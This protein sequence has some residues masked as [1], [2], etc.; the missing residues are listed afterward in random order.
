[1]IKNIIAVLL[2][3]PFLVFGQSTIFP[4]DYDL[5]IFSVPGT[6]KRVM[7]CLHGYGDN[8]EIVSLLK[9][10]KCMDATL[11]GFN[12]PEYDIKRG[13]KYDYRKAT[14]GTID[15]LLPALYVMK[16]IVLDLGLNSIDLYDS[17][18]EEEL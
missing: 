18:L 8:Y 1:M 7:I 6:S 17:L 11:I 5:H 4:F 2:L 13:R 12:F 9:N 10:L 14:F 16:K 3:S 15:E